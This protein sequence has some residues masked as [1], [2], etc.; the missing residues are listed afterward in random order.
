MKYFKMFYWV[1]LLFCSPHLMADT[2]LITSKLP[3][4]NIQII[5]SPTVNVSSLFTMRHKWLGEFYLNEPVELSMQWRAA[6]NLG[7]SL[8]FYESDDYV[9]EGL[10]PL[11]YTDDNGFLQM[12]IKVTP[13]RLGKIYLKFSAVSLNDNYQQPFAVVMRLAENESNDDI[14]NLNTSSKPSRITL[15]SSH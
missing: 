1:F 5:E 3:K 13:K 2:V 10:E 4:S 9:L 14:E 15:P 7:F 8:V 11:Y 6:P 12:S